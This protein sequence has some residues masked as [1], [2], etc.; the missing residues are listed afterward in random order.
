MFSPGVGDVPEFLASSSAVVLN[1]LYRGSCVARRLQ[2]SMIEPDSDI[3]GPLEGEKRAHVWKGV[4]K[5]F[6]TPGA[7][8]TVWRVQ[9]GV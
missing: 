9:V 7:L 4:W 6:G 1:I 8:G 3:T 2:Y 5:G